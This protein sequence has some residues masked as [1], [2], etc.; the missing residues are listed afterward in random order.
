MEQKKKKM[1]ITLIAAMSK[2]NVIGKDN[3][4]PSWKI[5]GDLKRFKALT[6]GKPI[7]MGR[8]TFESLPGALL[9]RLNV[10]LTRD[11]E[12]TA[13]GVSVVRSI[14]EA[15][16]LAKSQVASELMIIGGGEIYKQFLPYATHMELTVLNEDCEGDTYFPAFDPTRW[17]VTAQ[18]DFE[19]HSFISYTREWMI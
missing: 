14:E 7:V 16:D 9:G 5:P 15:I 12:W 17:K 6:M 1:K 11:P 4:L 2:N 8:K 10:V 3:S 18:E 13:N 19:R